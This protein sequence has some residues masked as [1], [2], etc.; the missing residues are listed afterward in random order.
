MKNIYQIEREKIAADAKEKEE[1]RKIQRERMETDK[2]VAII[3]ANNKSDT[4]NNKVQGENLRKLADIEKEILLNS[5]KNKEQ[6][7]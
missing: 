3:Y 6:K 4:E 1:D 5:N 7:S 2:E